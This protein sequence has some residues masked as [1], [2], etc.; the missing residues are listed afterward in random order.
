MKRGLI[1][2]AVTIASCLLPRQSFAQGADIGIS[3]F[4]LVS[5][6]PIDDAY[7]G[8]PYLSEG[9]GGFGPGFGAA[10]N[11]IAPNGFVVVGEFSTAR[12]SEELSGRLVEGCISN[13]PCVTHTTTLHDS[14]LSGLVGY[15]NTDGRTRMQLVG[16][17]GAKLDSPEVE[18]DPREP[19]ETNHDRGL[20]FV[21]TGGFDVMQSVNARLA[22]VVGARYAYAQRAENQR[23]LGVGPHIFRVSAGMRVRLAGA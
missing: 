5:F 23:Y 4:G 21:I 19:S 13:T 2:V 20:P 6:Q 16:G 18:G 3:G 11:V 8:S 12:Y 1:F 7:V 22:L 17:I 9:I 15:A 14:I 10:L